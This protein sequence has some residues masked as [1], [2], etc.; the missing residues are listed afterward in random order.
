LAL[1]WENGKRDEKKRRERE[2]PDEHEPIGGLLKLLYS[3][4]I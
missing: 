4:S 2:F 1:E 3:C